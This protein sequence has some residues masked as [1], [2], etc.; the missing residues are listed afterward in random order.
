MTPVNR[1]ELVARVATQARR[2]RYIDILRQR[3]D[4]GMELAVIDQL[5][6]LYNRR[7][8]MN[9][10]SL[11][12]QRAAIG[13]KPLSIILADIDHFKKVNDTYGHEA[14]DHVLGEFAK[15][16][17][18]NVRP[19]DI[20]CRHGGEEFAVIMP[21]TAGDVACVVAERARRAVAA[22]PFE[23]DG[24]P[25][26]LSVTVSSGVATLTPEDSVDSLIKRADAALYRAKSAGRNRVESVAA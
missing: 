23:V 3:V 11:L 9:Q 8:M 2:M 12:M 7:Y 15:R 6:G 26:S 22:E 5:T 10:L 24:V 14:G 16:L 25:V 13:S 18:A 20:V 1:Q 17:S 19:M 21:E 4:R